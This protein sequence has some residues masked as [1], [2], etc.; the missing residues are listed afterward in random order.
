MLARSWSR[1]SKTGYGI[2]FC[3]S[4]AHVRNRMTFSVALLTCSSI[5]TSRSQ[6]RCYCALRRRDPERECSNAAYLQGR[7]SRTQPTLP[8]EHASSRDRQ[9]HICES[10]RQARRRDCQSNCDDRNQWHR[11][12]QVGRQAWAPTTQTRDARYRASGVS[13]VSPIYCTTTIGTRCNMERKPRIIRTMPRHNTGDHAH[14]FHGAAP[15]LGQRFANTRQN[16]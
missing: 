6:R 10:A 15:I 4:F 3:H 2:H 7:L 13:A 8:I 16:E 9:N 14:R 12:E 5:M 11:A 1:Q